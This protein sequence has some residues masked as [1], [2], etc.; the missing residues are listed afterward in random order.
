MK[1][2]RKYI[3]R[4]F[5]AIK[6]LQQTPPEKC[7]PALI[8]KLRVEIKKV[9]ALLNLINRCSGEFKKT[10]TFGPF[11]SIYRQAGKIRDLQ[12]EE[13]F[14]Q[15]YSD[16]VDVKN[17]IKRVKILG[18]K[19]LDKYYKIINKKLLR[20][21]RDACDKCQ[22][23]ISALSR[24]VVSKYIM[25]QKDKVE[26]FA[27]RDSFKSQDIHRLRK[28]LKE[29]DYNRKSIGSATSVDKTNYDK[30]LPILLGQWHDYQVMIRHMK[31]IATKS[32]NGD[33]NTTSQLAKIKNQISKD[34]DQLLKKIKNSL[35]HSAFYTQQELIRN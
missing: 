2:L 9:K 21:Q 27:R 25:N 4:R 35:R 31:K 18:K 8:H 28:R 22:P 23:F 10:K 34:S 26:R 1:S 33:F 11:K 24:K 32:N 15:K 20:R 5:Y 30:D 3:W 29:F 13:I 16:H 19:R 12:L 14:L 7:S 17:Y 6:Y